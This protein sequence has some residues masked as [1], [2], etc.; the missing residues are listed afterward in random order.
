MTIRRATLNDIPAIQ[1]LLGQ[2]LAVHHAVRPDIFQAA[3][4]KC[5]DAE[6]AELIEHD[7]TPVFV[8]VNDLGEIIGHLFLQLKTEHS[9]VLQPV[10]SLFI[11]DL[12]VDESARGQK[13][14]EQ[15]YDFALN[16]AKQNGCYNLT[17]HVWNDN[18]GALRFY[19]K[20]GMKAQ[21]TTMEQI[22]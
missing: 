5:T 8:Y 16:F 4:S 14:G 13:I 2:I 19:E 1:R 9:S 6:L 20:R 22:L 15:L 17:L 12:C 7:T 3:G 21:S 11:E 10:K 18:A